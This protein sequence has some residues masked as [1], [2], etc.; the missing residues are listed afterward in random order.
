MTADFL[1]NES[2]T[3]EENLQLFF[4]HMD[5]IDA[6]LT[7]FLRRRLGSVL[8]TNDRSVFNAALVPILDAMPKA[9]EKA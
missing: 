8:T 9:E 6:E 7:G 5:G 4:D 3:V 1:F 2:K